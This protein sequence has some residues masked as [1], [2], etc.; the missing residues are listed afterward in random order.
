M[1]MNEKEWL[2]A[3]QKAWE[4]NP[5]AGCEQPGACESCNLRDKKDAETD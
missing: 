1:G 3:M 2:D 4:L 5:C